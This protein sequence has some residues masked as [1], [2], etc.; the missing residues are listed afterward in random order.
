MSSCLLPSRKLLGEW[1]YHFLIFHSLPLP[2][3]SQLGLIVST[4]LTVL[5]I[6]SLLNEMIYVKLLCKLHASSQLDYPF[7]YFIF[8]YSVL[9]IWSP[10][11]FSAFTQNLP[12]FLRLAHSRLELTRCSGK[13]LSNKTKG[14]SQ[15]PYL[16]RSLSKSSPSDAS[17]RWLP[18]MGTGMVTICGATII[19]GLLSPEAAELLCA[20]WGPPCARVTLLSGQKWKAWLC[21]LLCYDVLW[22]YY[23]Q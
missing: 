19:W 20:P 2:V 5:T 11:Q 13:Y 8:L 4:V 1:I 14:S 12:S 17:V 23:L 21:P 3:T 16:S 18:T 9:S 10:L 22:G 7:S 15:D 6:V